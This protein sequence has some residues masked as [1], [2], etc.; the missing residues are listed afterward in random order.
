MSGQ[1]LSGTPVL[2]NG[3]TII[4]IIIISFIFFTSFLPVVS[5]LLRFGR[6]NYFTSRFS[7]TVL[8]PNKATVHVDCIGCFLQQGGSISQLSD[9]V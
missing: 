7:I 3:P 8:S 4:I 2:E 9:Q 6:K 1:N 5:L